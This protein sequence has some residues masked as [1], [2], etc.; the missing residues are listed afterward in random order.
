MTYTIDLVDSI[1]YTTT[2]CFAHQL[3]E[4]LHDVDPTV[5]TV[6]LDD[7]QRHSLPN[8]VVCRLKQRTLHRYMDDVRRWAGG[9]PIVV[10]DQDPWEA[11]RDG[12]PYKGTY[13]RA[14]SGLNVSAFAVTTK[15]WADFL[16]ER[17]MPA[18]FVR[19]W[20]QPRYCA[21]GPAFLE[22]PVG[23]GFVGTVHPYRAQLFERLRSLGVDVHVLGGNA[24]PYPQYVEA[25]SRL[26]VF[27]HC[28]DSLVVVDGEV[29]N[30]RDGL[31]IKD[32]EASARGCFSIRNH[33]SGCR[34]YCGELE[35]VGLYSDVDDVP[36]ILHA[37]ETMDAHER[38]AA[39]D[40]SVEFIRCSGRWQE[41]ARRLLALAEQRVL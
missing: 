6:A 16:V 23:V 17:G 31:W 38:Q 15:W 3:H 12:S 8:R 30:L 9:A 22:R 35:T 11:F 40:R 21:R 18:E 2:N 14:M 28:E 32:V 34:T 24:M 36:D 1:E 25:L 4:A 5:Q 13:H 37:I 33:G 7:I 20:V 27:I 29:A 10:F 19:M 39:I 41:T 26:R